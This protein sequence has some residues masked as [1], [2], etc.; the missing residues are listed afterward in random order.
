MKA[1]IFV[2]LL[3]FTALPLLAQEETLLSGEIESGGFG[4][5]AIKF[6]TVN[7]SGAVFVGGRG[8]W[9]INHT[10]IVGLGGYGLATEVKARTVGPNGERYVGLGYGG[11]E[12][13]YILNSNKLIH[14]SVAVLLGGGG[15]GRREGSVPSTTTSTGEAFFVL[16]PSAQVHLNVTKYFRL[17]GGVSYRYVSNMNSSIAS[18]TDLSGVSAILTARFGTF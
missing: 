12:L 10:L 18:A 2:V 17:S 13:E 9:I 8:G 11:A 7:G 5:P 3:F 6:S 16:E 14:Y 4:G 15:I 1:A